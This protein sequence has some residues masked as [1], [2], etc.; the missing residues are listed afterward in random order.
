MKEHAAYVREIARRRRQRRRRRTG[1]KKRRERR[2]FG[3]VMRHRLDF[4]VLRK[5]FDHS[6]GAVLWIKAIWNSESRLQVVAEQRHIGKQDR[7]QIDKNTLT[8]R[9]GQA[10]NL[11]AAENRVAERSRHGALHRRAFAREKSSVLQQYLD[12]FSLLVK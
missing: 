2:A 11:R 3:R 8:L 4:H 10:L 5:C 7:T 12:V 6:E 1:S 9:M